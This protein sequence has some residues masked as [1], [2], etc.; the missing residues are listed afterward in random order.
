MTTKS[1]VIP[2]VLT[3][4]ITTGII[5]HLFTSNIKTT[6]RLN[7]KAN[8][9]PSYEPTKIPDLSDPKVREEILRKIEEERAYTPEIIHLPHDYFEKELLENEKKFREKKGEE[10]NILRKLAEQYNK[11]D[12]VSLV[13]PLDASYENLKIWLF[14]TIKQFSSKIV[15]YPYQFDYNHKINETTTINKHYEQ[16]AFISLDPK[17]IDS[18]NFGLRTGDTLKINKARALFDS[19]IAI[20]SILGFYL[21]ENFTNSDYFTDGA[22]WRE[23]FQTYLNRGTSLSNYEEFINKKTKNP[24]KTFTTLINE[25]DIQKGFLMNEQLPRFGILIIPDFFLSAQVDAILGKLKQNGIDKIK[26]FYNKGGIIFA[27]G[28][29]GVLLEEFGLVK[30]NTYNRKL[31]LLA[32]G[33]E[34]INTADCES[35]YNKNYNKDVDDF[36]KQMVCVTIDKKKVYT[37]SSTYL[38]SQSDSSFKTLV[39]IDSTNTKLKVA[40]EGLARNLTELEK[41]Y[42]PLVSHKTNDKNGQI[43]LMNFNPM[44]KSSD[45]NMIMNLVALAFSKEMYITSRVGMSLNSTEMPDMPIPAGEAGFN[46]EINTIIHNLDDKNINNANLY[47]FLPN[48]FNW[49]QLPQ[50]CTMKNDFDNIPSYIQAKRTFNSENNYIYCN[51]GTISTFEKRSFNITILVMNYK[52]TQMKYNV[53][54]MEAIMD[55]KDSKSMLK[56]MVDYIKVNCEAAALLRVS[57]N[58]DPSSFYPLKGEGQYVD[59]VIK[60]ENKEQTDADEVEYYGLIPLVSPLTDGDDQSK[61]QRGLK[62]LPQYYLDNKF[63]VPF[64]SPNAQD[65]IY[66]GELSGKGVVMV[67]EWDSPV[68]PVKEIIDQDRIKNI[69]IGKELDLKGINL[70]MIT[71]EKQTEIIKQINYRNS[72]RFYKLASQRLMVYVDDSTLKGTETLYGSYSKIKDE[73]KDNIKQTAKREFIFTRSD[74]YFYENENYVNPSPSKNKIEKIVFSVDKYKTYQSKSGCVEERGEARSTVA[75]EGY[76]SDK[77]EGILKP[78]IWSNEMFEYCGLTVI[79]PSD[80]NKI[81]EYFGD[82]IKPVHYLIPNVDK[83]ITDPGQIYEFKRISSTYGYHQKYNSVKFIYVHNLVYMITASTCLYGGRITIDL[84]K[85]PNVQTDDVTIS[86][87]QIAVYQ[88]EKINN[89]I[90][91]S[92]RRG[93]MSNEQFGKDLRLEIN[94]ENMPIQKE[95]NLN[96]KLEELKY[97]ISYRENNYERYYLVSQG[98]YKFKYQSAWS[99]PALEIRSKLNRTLNGYE[100]MEPFSRYGV[101]IQ[102]LNHRTVYG[103]AEAH[104]QTS[105]GL[106]GNG[107]GFSLISNLGTSSIPFIEYLTVGKGQVIPSGSSTSRIGWKDIWGR[108]WYQPLRSLFPDV[109]P[110]PPPLKNF[111]MTTTYEIVQNGKQIYE[112]PSDENAK[113]R[114]HIKLLNNYPKYFEITRCQENQIRYVPKEVGDDYSR[115]Y[116]ATCDANLSDKDFKYQDKVYLR[117]GGFASYGVC[118]LDKGAK[119]GGVE[120]KGEFVQQIEKAKLCADKTNADDIAQCAEELKDIITLKKYEG[121]D[122][123]KGGK[124]WN[125][126]P[127]VE[128]Y[129]PKGYITDDMWDMTHV[130][131][132]NNNMDKAYK[133]HMDNLIPNLDNRIYKPHN[134][135]AVPIFKGL[136]YNITYDKNNEIDYHGVKKKGWWCDNL[137]NMDNTLVAGQDTCNDIS[138]NKK[139][140][141]TNWINGKL[142]RGYNAAS[143]PNVTNIVN[144]RIKNI[145]ACR[146]NRKRPEHN[147]KS[148]K[149]YYT[150]NV[151]QNNIIPIIVDLDA[152]DNRLYNYECTG[153]QYT[154]D[155]IYKDEGNLLVTPTSKDYLYFGANLRGEAKES[156]NVIMNLNY[157]DKVR[158]EGMVKVN[159]GGRFVYWNPANGPNSFLVVDDPVSVVNAKRND[160]DIYNNIFPSIVATFNSVVYH[161]YFFKDEGKLNKEWPFNKYYTNSYGFGDVAV[162]VY[163]GGIR[164][165]KAVLEP[166]KTTYAKI[167]F[168]NNCGFDWNMKG[169]AID[170]EYIKTKPIS[171]NDLLFRITHTIQAPLKYNFLKYSVEKKYEKYITIEPSD[172]NLDV[173]AEFFDFENINVVTIRDG[174]KGEYNLK[175]NVTRDF[176][177]HLRGK[178]IEIKIDLDTS[179]FDKFPGTDT[180]PIKSFHNYK[181]KIP[182]VYI[183][184]P[185]DDG[186]F[187]GKVLYTS[188]QASDLD[189]SLRIGVDWKIDGIK[190]VDKDTIDKMYNATQDENANEIIRKLWD[191]IESKPIKY[192]EQKLDYEYKKIIFN[193][194]KQDYP[195]FPQIVEGS[196]DIADVAFLVKSS[197]AQLKYGTSYPIDNVKMNYKQWN[198][199]SKSSNGE[200]PFIEARGAWITQTYSRTLVYKLPNGKFTKREEDK[201]YHDD[202][203][204]MMITINLMNS[205]NE[206]SFNTRYEIV[207]QKNID[208]ISNEGN[209]KQIKTYKNSEGQTIITFDINRKIIKGSTVSGR[210]YVYYYKYVD[211]V[212]ELTPEEIKNL[213]S[214]MKVT[215]EASAT[216]DLTEIA[217]ENEVTQHLRQPLTFSYTIKKGTSVYID[218]IVSGRRK[219][220]SIELIPKIKF[221]DNDNKDNIEME[222]KKLDRTEYNDASFIA[223]GYETIYGNKG[224]KYI[225]SV[226]DEEINKIETDENKKHK[227]IY[228]IKIKKSDNQ[229]TLNRIEYD[230]EDIGISL[231]EIILISLSALFLLLSVLFFYLGIQNFKNKKEKGHLENEVKSAKLDKL[232]AE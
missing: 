225:E 230:Q 175:I 47:L 49:T 141:I 17:E 232:L 118:F 80:T 138:V 189:F 7:K 126:S 155:N 182:S 95:E 78:H 100:T 212:E 109:P 12:D 29:S 60:V 33:D 99:Y 40:E 16:G 32:E 38:T 219:N 169:K 198:G 209:F 5:T 97:D 114:L 157:F 69:E 171:A 221:A 63:E 159:E 20:L 217:G 149:T 6:Q 142:L 185:Y 143:S 211:S 2:F 204:Y 23:F 26:E 43:F 229:Y 147:Y 68:L 13:D 184:V 64:E 152:N 51:L 136:G 111:M 172:H 55:Y 37:L 164:K 201:L 82:Q 113:I 208:Y 132:D 45:R 36:D 105:P 168:Y 89:K 196:P 180:D 83:D 192:T 188:A 21:N 218:M 104:Q 18:Y 210:L 50:G 203:G 75:E 66:A 215:Q 170:F 22:Y 96:I 176:P 137:Q 167:I 199:K 65:F 131:Y 34:K 144:D 224:K 48:N 93:L 151:N 231:I 207:I 58:P 148:Q 162:S 59:N 134:I 191:G 228:E 103:T 220:P 160:I 163:V 10:R 72:D 216:F 15:L 67:A 222:I 206:D 35:T 102:E 110:I 154:P 130:D 158:Y 53:L 46:L 223:K 81:K 115:V 193:G 133:Y 127:L 84:S 52:A 205:G 124:N 190:Y 94:I 92:F 71:L 27:T 226:E 181:V 125:Y 8:S 4:L 108:T 120:V 156:L 106:V 194:I 187:K 213:P 145:Y 227:I 139:S 77:K 98:Q 86:P 76:F 173:A 123:Q 117:Q 57:V 87:D 61:T 161:V 135:L 112:W 200:K 3:F 56:T 183:G 11:F 122:T 153:D 41:K 177:P 195:L 31:V 91:I 107:I 39:N 174:F 73:W 62:I 85:Y 186:P 179:Y 90:V 79:D 44:G 70:G 54:I 101:Y 116:S 197:V 14:T 42:L 129:Y 165:S 24:Q 88:K 146:Y 25:T 214:A 74:I 150:K 19:D 9:I 1:I 30:K 119:V 140:S 121:N 28:K 166:G 128:K 202:E 178:P